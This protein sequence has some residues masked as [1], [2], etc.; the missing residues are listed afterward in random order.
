MA[1][2]TTYSHARATLAALCDEVAS[3]REPVIIRRRN[4]ADVALVAADELEGLVETAHL[5]RPS[6]NAERL[7]TALARAKAGEGLASSPAE[8]RRMLGLGQEE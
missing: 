6:E 3:T 7:L 2:V 5:L 1:H 8:L 4:A